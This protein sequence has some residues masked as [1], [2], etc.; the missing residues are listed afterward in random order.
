MALLFSA[1]TAMFTLY[2]DPIS[3]PPS[4]FRHPLP[5]PQA[6]LVDMFV[7][8][9]AE[10]AATAA[11]ESAVWT[12]RHPLFVLAATHNASYLQT[13]YFFGQQCTRP[14]CVVAR[15]HSFSTRL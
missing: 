8:V 10:L 5:S 7:S 9:H 4:T 15:S 3:S 2:P 12:H 6:V 13:N 14:H 11:A 1:Q